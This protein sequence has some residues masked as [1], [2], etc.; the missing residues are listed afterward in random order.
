DDSVQLVT[1]V[2]RA[3][4]GK[5]LMAIAAGLQRVIK[6]KRYEKMLV[7]RPI[8]PLGRDIGYL[9]GDKDEKLHAWMGPIFDNLKFLLHGRP[10]PGNFT[11][12]QLFDQDLLEL[13]ALTYIRG[14]SLANVFVV[15]DE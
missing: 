14:R 9:P 2:G 15:V 5:T 13:E 4:T 10:S 1:L 12:E 11:T 8:M 6:D 3:G 7:S